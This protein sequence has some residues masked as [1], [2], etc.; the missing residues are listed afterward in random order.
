MTFKKPY[1]KRDRVT[2]QTVGDSRTQQNF[3]KECDINNILKKY[4]KTGLVEHVSLFKGN[5]EDLSDPVD[6]QTAL[7]ICIDAQNAFDSLPSSIRKR[8]ANNPQS[9]IEFVNDPA[10]S[11]EMYDLGLAERPKVDS[12]TDNPELPAADPETSA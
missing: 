6:Y 12:A 10:N 9:F 7:N 4:Q 2:F 5:Y 11:D 3:K 8:F 1:G